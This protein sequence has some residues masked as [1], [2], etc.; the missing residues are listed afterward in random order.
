MQVQPFRRAR[1]ESL[2]PPL[3]FILYTFNIL[4]Y[5]KIISMFYKNLI[6]CFFI[7]CYIDISHKNNPTP[8]KLAGHRAIYNITYFI[9]GIRLRFLLLLLF[10]SDPESS[11]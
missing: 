6:Y 3:F 11:A 10:L 7:T 1:P 2:N 9:S 4:S 8:D 5:F